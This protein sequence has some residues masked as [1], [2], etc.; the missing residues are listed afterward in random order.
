MRERGKRRKKGG[1]KE[2]NRGGGREGGNMEGWTEYMEE[3]ERKGEERR[4]ESY[5]KEEDCLG[6][7]NQ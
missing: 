2:R 3:S 6:S 5:A 7:W 1:R 4:A